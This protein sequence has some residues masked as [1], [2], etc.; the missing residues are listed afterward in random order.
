M[1]KKEGERILA[2]MPEN[3]YCV[4]LEI[5][6]R[7][8]S[9]EAFAK[10]LEELALEGASHFCFLIGGSLGLSEEVLARAKLRLSF[11]DMTFPHQLMRVILAEQLYRAMKIIR[12]E[13]YHK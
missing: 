8:F 5:R 10:K 13:P 9:S 1:L 2:R 4:A 12:G 11:S 3:A 7:S 6:G